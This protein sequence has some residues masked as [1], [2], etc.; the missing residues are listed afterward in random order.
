MGRGTYDGDQLL[1]HCKVET[2]AACCP[3]VSHFEYMLSN[4]TDCLLC[5]KMGQTRWVCSG[6]AAVCQIMLLAHTHTHPFNGPFSRT[7]RVGRRAGTR[8]VKPIWILLKQ[9]TVSGSGIS[10][11]Y[12]GLH[13]APDR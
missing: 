9:E 6:D 1:A 5:L 8:K 13:L 7:T 12:A 10:W 4:S 3:L 11:A 2:L